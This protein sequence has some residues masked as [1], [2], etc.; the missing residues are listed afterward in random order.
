MYQNGNHN[1]SIGDV[2][3][4]GKVGISDVTAM[5]DLLLGGVEDNDAADTNLDG[6]I[7]IADVTALIDYLLSEMWP[8]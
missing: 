6:G 5:I 7:D 4:D 1:M 8:N 3:G 2:D